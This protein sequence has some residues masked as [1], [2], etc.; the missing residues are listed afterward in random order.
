M[1]TSEEIKKQKEAD[2]ALLEKR[3]ESLYEKLLTLTDSDT[4]KVIRDALK[5]YYRDLLC[6]GDLIEWVG[7]LYDYES[8]GFYYSNSG[9]DNDGFLPDL[10]S[11]RQALGW[12]FNNTL[13]DESVSQKKDF[14][15]EWVK[16]RAI[17]FIKERQDENGYFY[18]PQW[19]RELTDS[20]PHRRGRDLEC[21]CELLSDFESAP[22]YDTPSGVKG[23]GLLYDGTP[24]PGF[25]HREDVT[26]AAPKEELVTPHLKD[27]DAFIAYLEGFDLKTKAYSVSNTI[28]SQAKQITLR[29][30]VLAEMGADYSLVDILVEWYTKN[31]DPKTGLF[32]FLAPDE[33]GLNGL[34]KSASA[35][36]RVNRAFPNPLPAIESSI[37]IILE[38]D[39]PSS[40]CCVMNPLCV[41]NELF[42]NVKKFG[43]PDDT[44]KYSEYLFDRA[45]EIISA[46][47]KRILI[48]KKPDGSYSFSPMHSSVTSQGHPVAIENTYEGDV[49]ATMISTSAVIG[50]LS[51]LL[52]VPKIPLFTMAD[53]MRLLNIMEEN[54]LA[55]EASVK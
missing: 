34:M 17:K 25:S 8:G 30:K 55:F 16:D 27:K 40:V 24:A 23:N 26:V 2:K 37:K 45:T 32:T 10:E 5:D 31:Q 7:R 39:N 18:H 4:A 41:T 6:D 19:P 29:D 14:Y 13:K 54:K 48:F 50:H 51:N 22:A 52:G 43:N 33:N 36:S 11:T 3:W 35:V 44:K 20:K 12:L 53:R 49:N 42:S 15:P 9:R 38:N 1:F 46:T 21:A 47:S 28:E